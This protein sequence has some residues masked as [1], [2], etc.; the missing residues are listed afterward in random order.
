MILIKDGGFLQW[1][2]SM[3]QHYMIQFI[4]I[5]G[6]SDVTGTSISGLTQSGFVLS[7]HFSFS[8]TRHLQHLL[9]ANSSIFPPLHVTQNYF[10]CREPHKLLLFAHNK[11]SGCSKAHIIT[12]T[13]TAAH[14][15]HPWVFS[16]SIISLL[17]STTKLNKWTDIIRE[18]GVLWVS[19]YII[20]VG[21]KK[22]W[23][24]WL[25]KAY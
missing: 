14:A 24:W 25:T 16:C 19:S 22:N 8:N 17:I 9:L 23:G 18:G 3:I 21:G 7:K 5:H 1:G 15:H 10:W 13:A 6:C 20:C 11:V 2:K 12:V 4:D